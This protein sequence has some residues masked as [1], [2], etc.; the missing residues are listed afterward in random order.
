[1]LTII[2][3]HRARLIAEGMIW[4]FIATIVP[5]CT[6][7]C[8]SLGSVSGAVTDA[9]SGEALPGATVVIVGTSLG[10]SSDINGKYFIQ[11]IPRDGT[12]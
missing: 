4:S 9:V 8:Q 6:G 2:Q 1:M 10:A 7:M 5:L 12:N 11:N 3:K